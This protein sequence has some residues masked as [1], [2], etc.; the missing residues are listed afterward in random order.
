MWLQRSW[1]RN[2]LWVKRRRLRDGR[3]GGS[4]NYHRGERDE[5][6]TCREDQG[7]NCDHRDRDCLELNLVL[8]KNT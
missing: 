6:L 5:S 1:G 7:G 2:I 8:R 3:G 4:V